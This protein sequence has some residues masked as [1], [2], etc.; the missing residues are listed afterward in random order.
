MVGIEMIE[1]IKKIINK[2]N[3][4]FYHSKRF[5]INLVFF[6]IF[7]NILTLRI[8]YLYNSIIK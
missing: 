6:Y 7:N 1:L 2:V 5:K 8:K 4:V 3:L